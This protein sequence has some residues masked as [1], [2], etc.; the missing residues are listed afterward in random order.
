[1]RTLYSKILYG[2]GIPVILFVLILL[3]INF[4]YVD[5]QLKV[6]TYSYLNSIVREADNK[7]SVQ[8]KEIE[9]LANV[10]ATYLQQEQSISAPTIQTLLNNLLTA[11][12]EY[13]VLIVRSPWLIN[14]KIQGNQQSDLQ[15]RR[16]S[17]ID[18]SKYEHYLKL[19]H[20]SNTW[21]PIRYAENG[22]ETSYIAPFQ[23]APNH[24]NGVI[25]V[26]VPLYGLVKN[27][28]NT[29]ASE[30]IKIL[31]TAQQD[32]GQSQTLL[33]AA[34]AADKSAL[35]HQYNIQ[36]TIA[37]IKLQHQS[38]PR[39]AYIED[40]LDG[41]GKTFISQLSSSF[42]PDMQLTAL[43]PK[44][45]AFLYIHKARF[46]EAMTV[47]VAFLS[48]SLLILLISKSISKPISVFTSKVE[49][50]AA[51][52]LNVIFPQTD[53]CIELNSLSRNLNRTVKQLRNYFSDIKRITAQNEK[54]NSE[55]NISHNVQMSLL[56]HHKEQPTMSGIDIHA[57]T[58]PAKEVGGDFYYFFNIDRDHTALVVG[59]V[60]GKGMPA[61]I[62]MAVCLSL[63][64]AQSANTPQPD[65]CLRK[66]NHLLM[67]EATDQGTF[68]T[69][70]YALI[71]QSTSE[72]IYANAGHNPPLLAAKDGR[73]KFLDQEHGVALA[74]VKN[75]HYRAYK[76]KLNRGDS[77]LL[78]TDG[79][80][81]AHNIKAEE[82]GE[83][84]LIE[85][86]SR[87]NQMTTARSAQHCVQ[88]VIARVT[89]F[90]RKCDQFDD[91]TLL[92]AMLQEGNDA[93]KQLSSSNPPQAHAEIDLDEK[94][95]LR[96]QYQA[97][98]RY[99][100][101][102]INHAIELVDTFC[103]D[104][105]INNEIAA[106]LCVIAD[107]FISNIIRYSE[108]SVRNTVIKLQIVKQE[109]AL[110]MIFQYHGKAFDPLPP[111]TLDIHQDWQ[112]RRPGGLGIHIAR[113]LTD[114]ISYTHTA[115]HN[116][117]N[118][119]KQLH[120]PRTTI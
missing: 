91:M 60:S 10:F 20:H 79:I 75:A 119:T 17:D 55:I 74:V 40:P 12:E 61:A 32:N 1:M 87:F 111:P 86:L 116:I 8:V 62:M 101:Q 56:P 118:I 82:F 108:A 70:F 115:E 26:Y 47:L 112:Q 51:G 103:Q 110:L 96:F 9:E 48:L 38:S 37:D 104:H 39:I 100:L 15:V 3:I 102:E 88:N 52:N 58:M 49:I 35:S 113:Q 63:F 72:L 89:H 92:C 64:K 76:M 84:R 59:D 19:A 69:L 54:I 120:S 107:E 94:P 34:P 2:L 41:E 57:C 73:V 11:N 99:D 97:T 85:C 43:L 67:Q 13:D 27:F 42:G 44:E 7:L 90:S 18:E 50:L 83:Q 80:T 29:Q 71:N 53:S 114:R 105:H 45:E 93:H 33:L 109:D 65:E 22:W 14:G 31:L 81:E 77:L 36:H 30:H 5:H 98:M 66:I 68:V 46:I 117:L 106:D 6:L 78:Y 23:S 28:F 95:N 4:L 21:S 16:L 25:V 24:S